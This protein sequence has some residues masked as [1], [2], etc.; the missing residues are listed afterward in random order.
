MRLLLD[1]GLPRSASNMLRERGWAVEHVGDL[2]MGRASDQE[3]LAHAKALDAMVVTLDADFH[4][5]LAINQA[6]APSVTRIRIEGLNAQRF[7]ELFER[8]WPLI[9]LEAKRGCAIT[10]TES[11][12]RFRTLP[13]G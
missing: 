9:E 10:I 3:I 6:T 11:N 7:V 13:F 1:Q 8:V 5:L 2:G 12:I 4:T